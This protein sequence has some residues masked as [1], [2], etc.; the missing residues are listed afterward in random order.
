MLLYWKHP[1][2]NHSH[3]QTSLFSPLHINSFLLPHY[4]LRV[5]VKG[6]CPIDVQALTDLDYIMAIWQVM[7]V[8]EN[9]F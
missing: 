1:L 3:L 7:C 9:W 8:A 2:F 5:K 4:E 6:F